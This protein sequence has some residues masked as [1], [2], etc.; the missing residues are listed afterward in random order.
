MLLI[1]TGTSCRCAQVSGMFLLSYLGFPL[2]LWSWI[3]CFWDPMTSYLLFYFGEAL[4]LVV[5]L[6]KGT[7][8]VNFCDL[9]CL[10]YLHSVLILECLGLE[11]WLRKEFF[12]KILKAIAHSVL[13]QWCCWEVQNHSGNNES[14]ITDLWLH[15]TP[16]PPQ[17][18]AY[19]VFSFVPVFWNCMMIYFGVGQFSFILLGA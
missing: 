13:V 4:R 5:F 6:E 19:K 17:P 12:L 9:P 18:E 7:W 14:F 8:K 10:K 3:S 2:L 1:Q 15:C 16:S 11:F